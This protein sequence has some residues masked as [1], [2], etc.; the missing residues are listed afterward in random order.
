MALVDLMSIFVWNAVLEFG[1]GGLVNQGNFIV[2]VDRKFVA[3]LPA[4]VDDLFALIDLV[5]DPDGLESEL[6][7]NAVERATL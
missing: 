3:V 4:E 2:V 6:N 5:G 7:G 1:N